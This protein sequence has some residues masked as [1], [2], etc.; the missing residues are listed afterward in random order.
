MIGLTLLWI[1][2]EAIIRKDETKFEH[3][4]HKFQYFI[5]SKLSHF[6]NRSDNLFMRFEVF[7]VELKIYEVGRSETE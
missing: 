7:T 6:Q 1:K 3:D 5:E 4:S 2:L